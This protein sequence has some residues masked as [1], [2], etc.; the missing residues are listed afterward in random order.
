MKAALSLALLSASSA[1]AAKT[2]ISSV[3]RVTNLATVPNKFIVEVAAPSDIPSKRELGTPH[4]QLYRSLKERKISFSV[5]KEYDSPGLFVGAALSLTDS[6]DVAAI[7]KTTGVLDIRPIRSYPRPQPVLSRPGVS[8]GDAGIPDSESTHVMTG[9]DKLHALGITGKGVKVGILD[10]GLD[11]THPF[12]GGAFGSGNKVAGGF[13]FVGDAYDGSNDPV[14]DDDPMDCAGHG[15]HVAGIVGANP[16]NEF[17][18]SG[19]AYDATLYAYRIFGCEGSVTDDVIVDA[20]LRG[21]KDG[22]NIL[23]MSLGGT[24]GWTEGIGSVVSSRI[25]ATGKIVTVAAGNE[26]ASGSWFTSGPANGINAI[27]VASVD[28]VVI[29]LQSID[30]TGVT[31]APIVYYATFP[32]PVE[33][34][35]PLYAT[36]N[37]TTVVDDACNPLPANTPDLSGFVV[38]VRRGTCTFVTKLANVAAFG[39]KTTLIYDNGNGFA[40][41]DV[42]NFTAVLIQAEDGVFLGQTLA[43]GTPVSVTFPQTGGGVN[44]E[45]PTG[46]LVS[47]FSTFG[48]SNDMFFKPAI[49]APGGNIPL[50]FP[51]R[52]WQLG[53]LIWDVYGHAVPRGELCV[54][55]ISQGQVR[56]RRSG[57]SYSLRVD[58]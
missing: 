15:T 53:A 7:L 33:G 41:I 43:A 51:G 2:S 42:G 58:G 19:V 14:P 44:F 3:N 17:N 56:C 27:S 13:D 38:L 9:V 36:S 46:G 5:H 22:M 47:T 16:G 25:A 37:D 31:H 39:A 48:P 20:L 28:N 6:Q 4:E 1:W 55:V 32:I 21:F 26:G 45:D 49:A 29:P 24:D 12:L 11:Y 40:G 23:T 50:D 30:V 34:T 57:R 54:A 35:L 10:T 52:S 8:P 18:I